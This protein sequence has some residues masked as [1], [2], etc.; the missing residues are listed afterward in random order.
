MTGTSGSTH[1]RLPLRVRM[2]AFLFLGVAFGASVPFV[3]ASLERNGELPMTFEFQS[4]AGPVPR[5]QGGARRSSC[6]RIG[7]LCLPRSQQDQQT[8]QGEQREAEK[9][10]RPAPPDPAVDDEDRR[11]DCEDQR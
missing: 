8:S 4:M 7:G 5:F 6:A 3:L 9:R 10:D 11:V 2:A 1:L